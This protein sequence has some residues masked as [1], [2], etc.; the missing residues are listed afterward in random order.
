MDRLAARTGR[1][2]GLVDYEGAPEAE[3][4]LV[5]MGSAAGRGRRGGR[6]R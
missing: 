1:R 6:A 4:V 5:L 2:Y 3:R